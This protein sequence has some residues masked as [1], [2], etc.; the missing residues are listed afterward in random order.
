VPKQKEKREQT[1]PK[2]KQERREKEK[3]PVKKL[4]LLRRWPNIVCLATLR[5]SACNTVYRVLCW[6]LT[7]NRKLLR[8]PTYRVLGGENK[9]PPVKAVIN[10]TLWCRAEDVVHPLLRSAQNIRSLFGRT[11]TEYYHE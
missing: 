8:L 2:K 11:M 1:S 3:P 4:T 5:L 6:L 9:K 10:Q 7:G